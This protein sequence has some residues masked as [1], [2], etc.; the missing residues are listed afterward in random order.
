MKRK[1]MKKVV[2]LCLTGVLLMIQPTVSYASDATA[3]EQKSNGV[4]EI[5]SS[6]IIA[7]EY[8][9]WQMQ[10]K[11]K[12]IS[13]AE[14]NNVTLNATIY[15][16]NGDIEGTVSYGSPATISPEQSAKIDLYVEE[17]NAY[18]V[19]IRSFYYMD[20]TGNFAEEKIDG[21]VVE[22]KIGN[23]IDKSTGTLAADT[24]SEELRQKNSELI[25]E[26]EQLASKVQELTELAG[27][28]EVL[29]KEVEDLQKQKEA[30]EKENKELQ[31]KVDSLTK[32]NKKLKSQLEEAQR[33][34]KATAEETKEEPVEETQVDNSTAEETA[35][36]DLVEYTD[37]TTA[38]IVQQALNDAGYNCGTPDGIAGAKTAEAIS[39]YQTAKGIT[40]NGKITDE[41]LR[42]LGIEEKVKAAVEAEGKK[43]LYKSD[44]TYEQLARNPDSYMMQKVKFSGK[45]LQAETGDTSYM[46]LAIN[47]DYDTILFVT[48]GKDVVDY[49]L[50]EDDMVTVYGE[51]Y[52][53]YSYEAVS[54]ATITLPWINADIIEM[55]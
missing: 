32:K 45:V 54:G 12:N 21:S 4:I 47:S 1:Q 6:E 18:S 8:G 15:D 36:T 37:K 35:A 34:E 23:E 31:E 10:Y 9:S 33:E 13:N 27:S 19:Q 38:R 20:T 41:L 22:L 3:G 2:A 43:D 28:A 26:N 49:R 48:Y 5:T 29:Q 25:A 17:G 11:V 14:I 30:L 51:S 52:G 50:L 7:L 55:Q 40:V 53:V 44:Y 46:R 24:T 39:A 42:S 16:A